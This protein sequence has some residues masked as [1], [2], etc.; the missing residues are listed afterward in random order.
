MRTE[1]VRKEANAWYWSGTVAMDFDLFFIL[2]TILEGMYIV[3]F[4][5]AQA[6]LIGDDKTICTR[7][8]NC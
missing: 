7:A 2:A 8:A 5:L 3:P 6:K 4:L 1:G